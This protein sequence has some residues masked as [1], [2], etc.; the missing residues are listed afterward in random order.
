MYLNPQMN[1]TTF[2]MRLKLNVIK[3]YFS[4][5]IYNLTRVLTKPEKRLMWIVQSVTNIMQH[6]SNP[7]SVI[8]LFEFMVF[9]K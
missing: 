6:L 7:T 1:L 5:A 4:T 2:E 9:V 8:S 3:F